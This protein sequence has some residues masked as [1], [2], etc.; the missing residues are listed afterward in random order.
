MVERPWMTLKP[1]ADGGLP[2]GRVYEGIAPAKS[3]K[4]A[5][6]MPRVAESIPDPKLPYFGTRGTSAP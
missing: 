1:V 4:E 3:T 5:T 6:N 2:V